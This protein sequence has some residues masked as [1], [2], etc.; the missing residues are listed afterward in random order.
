M[1]YV[2]GRAVG[3]G[4]H[5]RRAAGR[6]R[7]LARRRG[8]GLRERTDGRAGTSKAGQTDGRADGQA[9]GPNRAKIA[10]STILA[11]YFT[12]AH[13]ELGDNPGQKS[14]FNAVLYK[15]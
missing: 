3:H 12:Y 13:D 5:R 7:G 14:G 15:L 10:R 8:R 6:N 4:R 1:A 9:D 11:R 2:D